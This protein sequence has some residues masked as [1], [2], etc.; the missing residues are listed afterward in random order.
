MELLPDIEGVPVPPDCLGDVGA[1]LFADLHASIDYSDSPGEAKLVLEAA[2][3]ADQCARLEA[4]SAKRPTRTKGSMGQFVIEPTIAELRFQR[5]QLAALLKQ[6]TACAVDEDQLAEDRS[7]KARR[8]AN[9]R[10]QRGS[11]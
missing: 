7:A 5:Q 6:A 1:Q 4:E 11:S 9:V 2:K 3:V 8:A 10:W